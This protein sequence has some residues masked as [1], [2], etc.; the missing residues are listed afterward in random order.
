MSLEFA[1]SERAA[2]EAFMRLAAT[3]DEFESYEHPHAS[4]VAALAGELAAR[5]R[6]SR[7]DR[8]AIVFA[9]LL[10]DGG[11]AAMKRD[12][13]RRAGPLTEAER[14]DLQRHPVIGEQEA[15]RAGADRAVQLLVRWHQEW[16][17][18]AGY[19]DALRGEQIPL[20][21]RILRVADAYAALTDARPFRPAGTEAEARKHLTLWA[22]LEFDPQVV[23]AFLSLE[24]LAE[25]RSFARAG[26]TPAD[27]T[28]E[29]ATA[30]PQ[31]PEEASS[32]PPFEEAEAAAQPSEDLMMNAE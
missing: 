31:S 5:F 28:K 16:W 26:Q 11:E 30:P 1:E 2:G 23:R 22:G 19:P 14:L 24:G 13:I 15:A 7:A 20:G 18:G 9:A 17:S 29:E 6:L 25:L 12:Y 4:R 21:A 10:H 8:S 32:P 3:T 27:E